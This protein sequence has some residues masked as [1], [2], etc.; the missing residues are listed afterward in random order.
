MSRQTTEDVIRKQEYHFIKIW[1][2]RALMFFDH[3]TVE[4]CFLK[5]LFNGPTLDSFLFIA[6]DL[7]HNWLSNTKYLQTKSLVLRLDGFT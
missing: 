6:K 3:T 2:T 7:D 1:K 5:G 4:S